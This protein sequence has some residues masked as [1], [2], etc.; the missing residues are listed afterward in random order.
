MSNINDNIIKYRRQ[1]LYGKTLITLGYTSILLAFINTYGKIYDQYY[2]ALILNLN[3]IIEQYLITGD[4]KIILK[5]Y[6]VYQKCI[7]SKKT[8]KQTYNELRH[9]LYH[10]P[11]YSISEVTQRQKRH[12]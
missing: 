5:L 4:D 2:Y 7:S 12:K 8:E 10:L 11:V 6:L 3:N 9:T 1:E